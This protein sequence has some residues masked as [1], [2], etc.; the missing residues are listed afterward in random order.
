[1]SE[2]IKNR[3]L[4]LLEEAKIILT[5]KE[6]EQLEITDMG[7]GQLE[8]EGLQ[9]VTYINNENYC[10]KELI[11]LPN[12]TCPEHLHPP[13]GTLPGKK[14]TFRCRMG[15]VFLYVEG[16]ARA[17]PSTAPP[18]GK[19]DFYTAK[20]EIALKPGEQF[21]IHPGVKHWFK[22]GE[23]GAIVSE[24]STTSRDEYDI[25]TDPNIKRVSN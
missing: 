16:E 19:E 15:T 4:S 22:A 10:A 13:I 7:L 21:T 11:L 17:E 2:A 9:L 5:E 23:E 1:M 25:F 18:K 8:F 12:Q 24:F 14:E 6:V 3:V 20:K